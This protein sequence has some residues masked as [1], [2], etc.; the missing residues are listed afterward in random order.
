VHPILADRLGLRL[1]LLAWALVG[2]L[3]GLLV[4]H[5][6]GVAWLPALVFAVPMAAV[7][8]PVSLSAWY[9]CRALPLAKTAPV[10][11]AATALAAALATSGLWA[12]LGR[13]WWGAIDRFVIP[14][15]ADRAPALFALLTGLGAVVYALSVTVHY[16]LQAFEDSAAATRRALESQVG[17]R[18]AELRALR[19]QVDPHFLFNSLN[20]I[21]GLIAADPEK[22]R[23]MCHLLA[24]FL[25]DSLTLGAAGRIS[26][27]R[28]VALVEQYLRIEQV[29]FGARL[30]MRLDVSPDSEGVL[31]PPL[32]LQ[33]L[34]ENAV[35]H[36]I[37]TRLDG[38]V[39]D[40]S[41]RRSGALVVVAVANPRDADA[42]RRGLGFG[43]D[44]V[45]RR[46]AAAWGERA[47]LTIDSEPESYRVSLAVPADE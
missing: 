26:L 2:A 27:V 44:I 3:L 8:A 43:L 41:A 19:A 32:L 6:I 14:M 29:R 28:E 24:E 11:V 31:V 34:V 4:R 18:E 17:Q 1:Y 9:L 23:Q 20:S 36:G 25:R 40:L 13:I 5:L 37:A 7:A 15:G 33:P 10:Q 30:T 45:R 38:G 47:T 46:L 16:L 35:R 22:A 21:S 39:V 42:T 12:G